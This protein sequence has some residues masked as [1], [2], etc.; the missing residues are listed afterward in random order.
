MRLPFGLWNIGIKMRSEAQ[1]RRIAALLG[2][3]MTLA[4]A[5]EFPLVQPGLYVGQTP[6]AIYMAG[7]LMLVA[8]LAILRDHNIWELSWC[9]H[10]TLVG[11]AMVILGTIRMFNATGYRAMSDGTPDRYFVVAEALLFLLGLFLTYKGW[12]RAAHE[13]VD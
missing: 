1:S 8:G 13:T 6:A 11:W 2:P 9:V 5:A 12:S 10:V 4:L 3:S 7:L